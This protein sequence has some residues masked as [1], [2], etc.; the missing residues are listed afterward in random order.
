[1]S[2]SKFISNAALLTTAP[3][4]LSAG[5]LYRSGSCVR[6]GDQIYLQLHKSDMSPLFVLGG[7]AAGG[8]AGFQFY[9]MS[10]EEKGHGSIALPGINPLPSLP[11]TQT[12]Q[13]DPLTSAI[14][15]GLVSLIGSQGSGKTTLAAAILRR[16]IKQGHQV[17]VLNHHYEYGSY[18]PLKVYGKGD[19]LKQQFEDI[20]KGIEWFLSEREKRYAIRQNKPQ[21]EWYFESEPITILIEEMGEYSGNVD[22]D[23][24]SSFLK[25]I[26]AGVRKANLFVLMVSQGDT[27]EMLGGG[28]AKGLSKLLKEGF[29]K[30]ELT[31]KS[32]PSKIGGL[33]PTGQGTIA[34]NGGEPI[35]VKIPDV[36]DMFPKGHWELDFSDLISTRSSF[37]LDVE[38]SSVPVPD[39]ALDTSKLFEISR[40]HGW[41]SASKAKQLC[42]KLKHLTPD[43]MRELFLQLS[44]NGQGYVRGEG[45]GLEWRI[46]RVVD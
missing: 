42:W 26:V 20:E 41:V 25:T 8:I 4:L 18:K 12:H 31:A 19:T 13:S 34:T 37:E 1:M 10:R 16:R 2:L 27:L 32:D 29:I 30:I 23:L 38:S 24:M 6:Q 9:Q 5:M 39:D 7:L 46:E 28:S 36:R 33:A 35:P 15:S 11:P 43:Q 14:D 22:A 40:K 45:E 21:A 44:A 3:L 17:I